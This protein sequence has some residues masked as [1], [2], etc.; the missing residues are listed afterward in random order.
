MHVSETLLQKYAELIV[1]TGV[2]VQPGQIVQLTAAV[3][4][5]AFAAR[6]MEEC[7]R[8]GARKVNVDWTYDVQSRLNFLYADQETLAA[9]LPWEEAKAILP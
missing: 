4:Q 7:Y 2:N 8:A 9:V 1:R 5:H 3:D 6:V